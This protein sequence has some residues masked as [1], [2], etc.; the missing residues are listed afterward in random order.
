M[1]RYT[2][3]EDNGNKGKE[4]RDEDCKYERN[5]SSLFSAD[6]CIS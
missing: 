6:V 5:Y 4:H 3:E 1:K 2:R